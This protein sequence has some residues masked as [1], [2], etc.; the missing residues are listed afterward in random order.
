MSASSFGQ[1][2]VMT[3]FGESHGPALGVV[4]DGCPAGV[5]FDEALLRRELARRRPGS[6]TGSGE[7]ITS[8][9][10][11]SDEPEILSGVYQGVTLG[12][13][14]AMLVRNQDARS[15][16]YDQIAQTPRIGHADDVWKNKFGHSDPRG[17]GRSSGRETVARVMAGAVAQMLLAKLCPGISVRGFARQI[18]PLMLSEQELA[19]LDAESVSVQQIDAFAARLPSA[20]LSS[21]VTALL[22]SAKQQGRSFGGLA[23]LWIDGA[24]ASWGQPVFHKLKADLAQAMLS[25]GATTSVELGDGVDVASAEGTSFHSQRDRPQR[26]G[27]IRGGISTGERI[28]LRVACKPTASVLH[29]AKAG[30]HDPCIVPRAIPVLEAMAYVVLADHALWQRTDRLGVD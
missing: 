14:L 18:G 3:T 22:L 6:L 28:V 2:F 21:E 7:S 4:I 10:A 30:R 17:G 5:P 29:V 1:R 16:D 23:E 26:Y 20:R 19:Q 8:A 11:E 13:P 9:R 25:V 15:K 12:T 27:G 24:S